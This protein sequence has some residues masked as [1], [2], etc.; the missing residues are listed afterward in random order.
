[1][2]KL[3]SNKTALILIDL[4]NGMLTQK[5]EPESSLYLLR[6]CKA[7]ARKFR[8]SSSN[9]VLVNVDFGKDLEF[10]PR[11]I[12][13]TD[14]H[15][16]ESANNPNWSM[17]AD[18]LTKEGDFVVTKHQWGAF[19]GTN[20]LEHLRSKDIDTLVLGGISTNFGVEST[21]RQAWELGF[22]V[23]IAEDCC[24]STAGS[25]AHNFSINKIMTRIAR[26]ARSGTISLEK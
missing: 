24:S 23:V 26:I 10:Y 21:A 18:G 8:E 3:K 12:T 13:E 2:L 6:D 4:Q 25:D 11:G 22:N 16:L 17:L 14:N 5:T 20:L 15:N 19:T 9:V 1:M 7:L